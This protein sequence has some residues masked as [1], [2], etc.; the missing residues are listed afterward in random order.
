MHEFLIK[1]L[2]QA[3]PYGLY[4]LASNRGWVSVG[5]SNAAAAIAVRTIRNWWQKQGRERYRPARELA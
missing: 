4:E 2:G 3:V 5:M 1:R